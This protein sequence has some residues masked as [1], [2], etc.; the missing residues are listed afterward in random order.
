[1][2]QNRNSQEYF[3]NYST[4]ILRIMGN[5]FIRYE[6]YGDLKMLVIDINLSRFIICKNVPSIININL[7]IISILYFGKTI[8]KDYLT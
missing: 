8:L 6:G 5:E 1:M 3:L 7:K 4:L 2:Y